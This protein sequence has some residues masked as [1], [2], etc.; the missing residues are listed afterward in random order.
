MENTRRPLLVLAAV[1]TLAT[2]CRKASVEG[3]YAGAFSGSFMRPSPSG[4]MVIEPPYTS[5]PLEV[6]LLGAGPEASI[7]FDA[8]FQLQPLHGPRGSSGG[9]EVHVKCTLKATRV[10]DPA[11]TK[12]DAELTIAEQECPAGS[13]PPPTVEGKLSAKRGPDTF[14]SVR[15]EIKT[16]SRWG[17]AGQPQMAFT[18]TFQGD[19]RKP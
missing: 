17:G 16:T 3:V 13:G 4:G 6:T 2:G 19:R 1:L 9:G 5:S 11:A 10:G 8:A 12:G 7:V 14:D 15:L 18:A